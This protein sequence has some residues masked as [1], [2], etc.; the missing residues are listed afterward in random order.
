MPP[1]T[2]MSEFENSSLFSILHLDIAS[3]GIEA[4]EYAK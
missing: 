4:V 3:N 2:A 1:F